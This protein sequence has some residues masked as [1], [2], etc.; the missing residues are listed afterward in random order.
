MAD[1]RS[2]RRRYYG[3]DTKGSLAMYIK[4]KIDRFGSYE[5]GLISSSFHVLY[6]VHIL[7]WGK[8]DKS[9]RGE[10][11]CCGWLRRAI[12]SSNQACETSIGYDAK[13]ISYLT[14]RVLWWYTKNIVNMQ[15]RNY[16]PWITQPNLNYTS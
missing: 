7:C 15:F 11:T 16:A 9:S 3:K 10:K 4:F 1:V 6:T 5:R 8:E 14:S 13:A 2:F 12:D